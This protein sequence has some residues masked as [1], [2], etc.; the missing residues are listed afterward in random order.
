MLPGLPLILEFPPDRNAFY[1]DRLKQTHVNPMY[2]KAVHENRGKKS[3][4]IPK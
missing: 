1:K 2:Y 4:E 3:V